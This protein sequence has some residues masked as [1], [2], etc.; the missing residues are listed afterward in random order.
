M[1]KNEKMN[2]H[3]MNLFEHDDA[4]EK[5]KPKSGQTEE[6][7]HYHYAMGHGLIIPNE[8]AALTID[9]VMRLNYY[10]R[11]PDYVDHD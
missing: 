8:M 11:Y 1:A 5:K 6:R 4:L 2:Y 9:K 3:S 7:I 10:E